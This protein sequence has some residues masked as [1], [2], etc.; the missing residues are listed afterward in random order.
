MITLRYAV[1]IHIFCTGLTPNTFGH[2][3]RSSVSYLWYLFSAAQLE[4]TFSNLG[5]LPWGVVFI[6]REDFWLGFISILVKRE[7]K[8][9]SL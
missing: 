7:L 6:K 4:A 1:Y 8:H 5:V 2:T 9:F 3:K